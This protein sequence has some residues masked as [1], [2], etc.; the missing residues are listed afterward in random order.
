MSD[1]NTTS[2]TL[3]KQITTLQMNPIVSLQL[4]QMCFCHLSTIMHQIMCSRM[5]NCILRMHLIKLCKQYHIGSVASLVYSISLNKQ[6]LF[7]IDIETP[8]FC[9]DA[10]DPCANGNLLVARSITL[11]LLYEKYSSDAIYIALHAG[12][13]VFSGTERLAKIRATQALCVPNDDNIGRNPNGVHIY[14]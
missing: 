13:M 2:Y 12:H 4:Q 7:V 1:S 11:N 14:F 3:V 9:F 5:Y 8:L 10:A 6:L